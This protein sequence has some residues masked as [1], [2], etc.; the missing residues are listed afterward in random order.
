MNIFPERML[1]GSVHTA[2]LVGVLFLWIAAET[3]GFTMVGLVVPGYLAAIAITA[4]MSLL[5]I[6]L[7]AVLTH[8][9]VSLLG[10][11]APRTGLWSR[12]FGR[13]R[14]LA[15]VLLSVP[16]R[17]FVESLVTPH[18]QAVLEAWSP[19]DFV[20]GT[21]FYSIG[22]VLVPLTA[23]I[24]WKLGLSRGAL[25]VSLIAGF[26]W[27]FL[28]L[29]LI[30]FT[31]FHFGA[32]ELTFEHIARDFLSVPKAYILLVVTAAIASRNNARYGWDGGGIMVPALLAIT[33]LEPL[34]LLATLCEVL[35]L[36]ALWKLIG[37]IP[38]MRRVNLGGPRAIAAIY[39]SAFLLKVG[40]ALLAEAMAW[41]VRVSDAYGFG[42]LLTTLLASKALEKRGIIG[43]ILP[44]V[45]TA[46]QGLVVGLL[47][48]VALARL[49]PPRLPLEAPPAIGNTPRSLGRSLLLAG[50]SVRPSWPEDVDASPRWQAWLRGVADLVDTPTLTG[51]G[52]LRA[53]GMAITTE[54]TA[55]GRRCVGAHPPLEASELPVGLPAIIWCG[56]GGP[57]LVVP[58]PLG[59]PDS[60]AVANFLAERADVSGIVIAGVDESLATAPD[61]PPLQEDGVRFRAL[62]AALGDRSVLLVRSR[63]N[64]QTSLDSR[65]SDASHVLA[66]AVA[67]LG[68][69]EV[70]FDADHGELQHLWSDLRPEDGI[71]T[72]AVA[73]LSA[74]IA[75]IEPLAPPRPMA[76]IVAERIA[77]TPQDRIPNDDAPIEARWTSVRQVLGTA[78]RHARAGDIEVPGILRAYADA[79]RVGV[80]QAVDAKGHR[81]WVLYETP[82]SPRGWGTWFIRTG[83]ASGPWTVT[84]PFSTDEPGTPE[85]AWQ[86]WESLDGANL[87][88][89]GHGHRFGNGNPHF[90]RLKTAAN[91][92]MAMRVALQPDP[93]WEASFA[94][95]PTRLLVVRRQQDVGRPMEVVILSQGAEL[96]LDRDRQPLV[97]Q[98]ERQL[99]SWPQVGLDD[100]RQETAALNVY[101]EFP[102]YYVNAIS[103]SQAA[104]LWVSPYVLDEVRGTVDHAQRTAWYDEKKIPVVPVEQAEGVPDGWREIAAPNHPAAWRA[105]WHHAQTRAEGSLE[106][107]RGQATSITV[108]DTGLRLAVVARGD[109]WL[110]AASNKAESDK[111]IWPLY[112]CWSAP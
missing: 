9:V 93:A 65:S 41:Q 106:V 3:F 15:V 62:R 7:E 32:F 45:W 100:G 18:A 87:W 43:T 4:P 38:F 75:P 48:S 82:E 56:G 92:Q 19:G 27:A 109:D 72:V 94:D 97:K 52:Q 17:L 60:L 98:L 39:L 85:A 88:L 73:D 61:V 47:I 76:D 58:R 29:V 44:A 49:F 26:T 24:F 90:P 31:N 35:V 33:A 46:A 95:P 70:K 8:A 66:K 63:M 14:F 21:G 96:V 104:V 111:P 6:L 53:R 112:G 28:R 12:I 69:V 55:S 59:D 64:G 2:V 40:L 80:D 22:V 78:V 5:A 11:W 1:D 89:S 84:A 10:E 108:V 102:V 20:R 16:V 25:Q 13:D 23:N 34:K 36:V 74:R 101:S 51:P 30:P 86:L 50:A 91:E 68:Q 54:Q 81:V 67:A 110:C 71:L 107:L 42:Y 103:E 99:A 37:L 77:A 83:A 105:L 57:V 79:H